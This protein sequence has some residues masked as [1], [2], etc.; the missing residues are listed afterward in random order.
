MNETMQFLVRQVSDLVE[1][2]L[3]ALDE[4]DEAI[5]SE[6]IRQEEEIHEQLRRVV[7]YERRE[8]AEAAF[9]LERIADH[10]IFAT[11]LSHFLL[12]RPSPEIDALQSLARSV[13][14]ILKQSMQAWLDRDEAAAILIRSRLERARTYRDVFFQEIVDHMM[15]NPDEI[16]ASLAWNAVVQHWEGIGVRAVAIAE[17]VSELV[18]DWTFDD[19]SRS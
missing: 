2:A 15:S 16:N 9:E 18:S 4:K 17:R 3:R 5:L 11:Q 12:R 13:Q 10:A 8:Y 1:D 14:S 19:F 6:V 7:R